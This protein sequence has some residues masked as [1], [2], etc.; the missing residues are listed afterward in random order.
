MLIYM[1]YYHLNRYIFTNFSVTGNSSNNK[2]TKYFSS[3]NFFILE[4][5]SVVKNFLP[6]II[7]LSFFNTLISYNDDSTLS[8]TNIEPSDPPISEIFSG[9]I[10][11]AE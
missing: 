3:I 4:I 10:Y 5:S 1:G 2:L 9:F 7:Q 11:G 6:N 8:P